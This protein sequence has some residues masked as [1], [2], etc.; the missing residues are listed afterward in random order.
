MRARATRRCCSWRRCCSALTPWNAPLWW[1]ARRLRFAIELD[2][3][4]RVLKGRPD[5][6]AYGSLLL[7]V[8]ERTM[9]GAMPIAALAEPVSL[10]E[11]R[12]EAMTSR[13]PRFALVRGVAA[14]A[15][16]A[17]LVV[18]ACAA[19][20]PASAPAPSADF[21]SAVRAD[22]IL[23]ATAR[24]SITRLSRSLDSLRNARATRPKS[25]RRCT[26]SSTQQFRGCVATRSSVD[27]S[28]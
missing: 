9:G 12:I 23:L 26:P 11:R 18:V 19:P 17:A 24:D 28:R 16:A 2:C 22:S 1:M 8:S 3:D 7:D 10:I 27:C 6:S 5:P 14:G 20:H 4:A 25:L 15:I 21:T 13:L